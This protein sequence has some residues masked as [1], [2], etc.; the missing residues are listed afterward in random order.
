VVGQ[1]QNRIQEWRAFTSIESVVVIVIVG[2]LLALALPSL[3]RVR[4]QAQQDQCLA[5][6]RSLGQA[7]KAYADQDT[8]EFQIPFPGAEPTQ[9]C[10]T[11]GPA[12]NGNINTFGGNTAPY[13]W[14]GKSGRGETN[15]PGGTTDPTQLVNSYWGTKNGRGPVQRPMNE[16]FYKRKFVDHRPAAFGG[17]DSLQGQIDDASLALNVY[18][19]PADTGYGGFHVCAWSSSGLTSYDH[20]GTSYI[21]NAFL[22]GSSAACNA[23]SNGPFMRPASRIPQPAL[24][25]LYLENVG[26]FAP[27]LNSGQPCYPQQLGEPANCDPCGACGS[28]IETPNWG[29]VGFPT[30]HGWHGADWTFNVAFCDGSAGSRFIQGHTRPPPTLNSYPVF[31]FLGNGSLVITPIYCN[32]RCVIIRRPDWNYDTLPAPPVRTKFQKPGTPFVCG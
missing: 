25:L 30:I 21:C 24:T 16:F 7:S 27:R 9:L 5:N 3:R 18:R 19:C 23:I 17:T 4:A 26:R 13:H 22:T 29:G 2:L 1:S 6:L 10:G 15:G 28:G 20:Y 12:A 31:D 11:P 14:G 8:S 32:Y